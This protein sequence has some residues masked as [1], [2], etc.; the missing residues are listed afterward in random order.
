M[1]VSNVPGQ[2][3]FVLE[4]HSY[5]GERA[6][7]ETESNGSAG[8]KSQNSELSGCETFAFRVS[9]SRVETIKYSVTIPESHEVTVK[10]PTHIPTNQAAE[11]ILTVG[12]TGPGF[13]EQVRALKAAM[14]DELFLSDLREVEQDFRGIDLKDWE[15]ADAV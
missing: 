10:V 2:L 15:K 8:V 3:N 12:R 7:A 11:V 6:G 9:S 14:Q 13:N 5:C 4:I 1:R